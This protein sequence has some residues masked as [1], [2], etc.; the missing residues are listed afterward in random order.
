MKND[1]KTIWPF[2]QAPNVAAITTKQVIDLK[3]PILTVVHY[4]DDDS[5]AF[6]C[7]T[8]N[9]TEDGRVISMKTALNLDKSL[10]EISNLKPG[11]YATR[12]HIGDKWTIMKNEE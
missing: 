3:L 12:K 1:D 6:L 4:F 7:G 9:K 10:A 5:W 2:D 11:W 8:S